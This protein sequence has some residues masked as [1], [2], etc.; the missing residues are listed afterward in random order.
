M[1]KSQHYV[2]TSHITMKTL[3][4]IGYIALL[5]KHPIAA[6]FLRRVEGGYAQLDGLTSNAHFGSL[7][8]HE[9]IKKVVDALLSDAKDLRLNGIMAFTEDQGVLDR[10]KTI[11]FQVVNQTLIALPLTK[12][13]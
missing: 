1:L 8:R 10:A 2:D 7:I 11:G 3:P 6:G 13:Q 9:G 4:K 5:N 12:K